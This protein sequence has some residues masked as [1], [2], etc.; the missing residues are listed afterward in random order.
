MKVCSFL[1]WLLA[2][3]LSFFTF[4]LAFLL[5]YFL[6][7]FLFFFLCL[8]FVLCSVLGDRNC[9]KVITGEGNNREEYIFTSEHKITWIELLNSTKKK[10]LLTKPAEGTATGSVKLLPEEQ[11]DPEGQF[12]IDVESRSD[13]SKEVLAE[14]IL[15]WNALAGDEANHDKIFREMRKL[16]KLIMR[17]KSHTLG[18]SRDL[19]NLAN[20]ASASDQLAQRGKTHSNT[21]NTNAY[22]TANNTNATQ[23]ITSVLSSSPPSGGNSTL[24]SG[25]QSSAGCTDTAIPT[26]GLSNTTTTAS[27]TTATVS[28][29][30]LMAA[31]NVTAS[32]K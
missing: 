8:F 2:F 10:L 25:M 17:E 5:L 1:S 22:I 27:T 21:L 26:T 14:K 15:A 20:S 7:L 4:L 32:D 16:S 30:K 23:P 18:T 31:S 28:P 9:F 19:S 24:L 29:G 11:A 13:L 6:F 12:W 3:R